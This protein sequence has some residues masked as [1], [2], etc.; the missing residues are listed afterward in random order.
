VEVVSGH[1]FNEENEM[2][3]AVEVSINGGGTSW[4]NQ[5]LTDMEGYY[6]FIV[7]TEN[8]YQISPTRNDD[9][10]NGVNTL[11]LI[12]ISQHILGMDLL[13]SPYK[14]IAADVNNSGSISGFDLVDLRKV[15]LNITDEFPNNTSW[16]FVEEAFVFPDPTNPFANTFP[17]LT[18]INGLVDSEIADFIGVKTGDVNG[19]AVPNELLSGDT[20][21]EKEL[22]FDV[23]DIQLKAG[24]EYTVYF[25]A[26]Q[27]EQITGYQFTL[28]FDPQKLVMS[29][30]D[31]EGLEG[32]SEANFGFAHLH[33]G[34][35][36]TSWNAPTDRLLRGEGISLAAQSAVFGIRFNALEN[37]RL[38]EALRL[39]ASITT[40]EAYNE[41]EETMDLDL[42]F[43]PLEQEQTVFQFELLQN[44]PN[45]FKSE[46]SIGFILPEASTATL[47]IFD[48]A[49][50]RL[51][52]IKGDFVKGYNEVVIDRSKI[53]NS[54]ILYYRLDTPTRNAMKRMI[55]LHD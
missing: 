8:N 30:L 40:A 35:I 14:F 53:L 55:M 43:L 1:V 52:E 33:E 13:D 17:E 19:S 24:E 47:T 36:T 7:P 26:N 45:P 2:I 12:M 34:R 46:T 21:M 18:S 39:D 32:L 20:R 31:L 5:W 10:L 6:E 50:Q 48:L 15:I 54:G 25:N 37:L 3:E 16:R 42:F 23:Q 38:S 41:Q 27:F 49:G 51:E 28:N 29:D 44:Y 11:D 9:P 22:L 4:S